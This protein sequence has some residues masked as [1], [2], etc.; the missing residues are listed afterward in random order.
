MAEAGKRAGAMWHNLPEE[1]KQQF[2]AMHED[3]VSRFKRQKDEITEKG[4][5]LMA[6]G[7]RSCDVLVKQKL[8]APAAKTVKTKDRGTQTL[9]VSSKPKEPIKQK[10]V[11]R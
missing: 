8:S 9:K 11:F 5:F 3:D 2:V 1:D 4:F 7:Q 6:D 10:I